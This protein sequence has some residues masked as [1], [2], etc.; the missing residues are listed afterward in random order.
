MTS[1]FC[2]SS[3][4]NWLVLLVNCTPSLS[5]IDHLHFRCLYSRMFVTQYATLEKRLLSIAG[6]EEGARYKM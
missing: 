1:F 3:S 5:D 6:I 2:N 4:A